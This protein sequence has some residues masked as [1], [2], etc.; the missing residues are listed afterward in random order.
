MTVIGEDV[1]ILEDQQEVSV[2]FWV[3]IL[4]LGLLKNN[5]LFPEAQQKQSIELSRTQQQN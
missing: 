1:L 2:P 4:S 5:H 3:L